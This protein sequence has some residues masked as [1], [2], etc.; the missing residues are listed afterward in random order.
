MLYRFVRSAKEPPTF[1]QILAFAKAALRG[2]SAETVEANWRWY[3]NDLRK[4]G[5]IKAV[6]R[7]EPE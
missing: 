1:A 3:V 5:L 2:K 4:K 6:E 7:K